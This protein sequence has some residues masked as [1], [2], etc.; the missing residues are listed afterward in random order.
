MK[1]I[2][3]LDSCA[4]QPFISN[5]LDGILRLFLLFFIFIFIPYVGQGA[6]FESQGLGARAQGMG[7]SFVAVAEDYSSI[8]WNPSGI[9]LVNEKTLHSEYK[10]LY[11]LG[12][13]RHITAGYLQPNVG[14]GSVAFS[15]YRLDTIG[16]ASFLDYSE[17][18]LVFSY[19]TH[20]FKPLYLGLNGKYYRVHS[21]IGASGMGL[22]VGL[23]YVLKEPW[24]VLGAGVQDINRTVIT[25]D[26]GVKER[27]PIQVRAGVSSRIFP[28]TLLGAQ[29]EWQDQTRQTHRLGI[30]QGF[31]NR[32]MQIRLGGVE[33]E[34]ELRFAWGLGLKYKS[35]LLDFGWERE[36]KLGDTLSYSLTLKL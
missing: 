4:K 16:E 13:L 2:I 14:K 12:L 32:V 29:V 11:G 15:W 19:A 30:E 36:E 23:T 24:L 3:F 27:L 9:A 33:R 17:N 25:W 26:S 7:G 10:N 21:S 8:F 6:V 28:D 34:Q 20:F 22:D 35:L 5:G 31:F 18:T 1:K